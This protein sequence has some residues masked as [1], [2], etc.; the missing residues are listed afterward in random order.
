MQAA[1]TSVSLSFYAQ[2]KCLV[3]L[4]L[5]LLQ[6][7]IVVFPDPHKTASP[8][9][10]VLDIPREPVSRTN[11]HLTALSVVLDMSQDVHGCVQAQAQIRTNQIPLAEVHPVLVIFNPHGISVNP[12]LQTRTRVLA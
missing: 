7:P 1:K 9:L 12:Q 2:S 4:H 10:Q 11:C 8:C 5:V 3:G 6:S